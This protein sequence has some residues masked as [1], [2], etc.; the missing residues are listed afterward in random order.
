ML[1]LFYW[2]EFPP[3]HKDPKRPVCSLIQGTVGYNAHDE[4]ALNI[5]AH[6]NIYKSLEFKNIFNLLVCILLGIYN[7][8]MEIRWKRCEMILMICLLYNKLYEL[9]F[10][11]LLFVFVFTSQPK[12]CSNFKDFIRSDEW[13]LQK[14]EWQVD[15]SRWLVSIREICFL[16]FNK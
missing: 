6:C 5:I 12:Q 8:L 16:F 13:L 15:Y 7:M 10:V 2:G 14:Y 9:Y 3:Q 4:S 1:L 11:C